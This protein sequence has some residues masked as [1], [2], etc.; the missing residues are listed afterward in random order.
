MDPGIFGMHAQHQNS[1]SWKLMENAPGRVQST[2]ARKSAVHHDQLRAQLLRQLNCLSTVAGFPDYRDVACVLEDAPEAAAH[3]AVV[4]DQQDGDFIG[5]AA[6]FFPL[7]LS[8][9]PTF[10]PPRA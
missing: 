6:P 1:S 8:S 5:H 4:I 2:H 3:Q 7:A 10:H 9:E